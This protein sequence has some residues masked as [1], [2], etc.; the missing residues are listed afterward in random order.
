[1]K[2]LWNEV[3]KQSQ[4]AAIVLFLAVFALAFGL[5]S[6]YSSSRIES[7]EPV[8]KIN[9]TAG[10]LTVY[11]C[12]EGKSVWAAYKDAEVTLSLSN[13]SN[14]TLP[15]VTSASGARYATKDESFVFWSKGTDAFI[16]E[17]G[18]TTYS[19][20]VEKSL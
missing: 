12:A 4:V 20:C 17:G 2:I 1:M 5:G 19:N 15:Q 11:E 9:P 8:S 10:G 14:I 13:G 3:T 18:E 7:F 16:E 6:R